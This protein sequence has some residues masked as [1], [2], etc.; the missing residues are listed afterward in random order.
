MKFNKN[1][2]IILTQLFVAAAAGAMAA[3]LHRNTLIESWKPVTVCAAIT[4]VI[5]GLL[6][7]LQ[8]Q[9][10]NN[11]NARI[12]TAITALLIFSCMT[13]GFYA[14]NYFGADDTGL[15]HTQAPV[16]SKYSQKRHH[17][18]RVGRN[19]YIPGQEYYVYYIALSLPN[20]KEKHQQVSAGQYINIRKGQKM[21]VDIQSGL[22]GVPVLKN[23]RIPSTPSTKK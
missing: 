9:N 2:A 13:C 3:A 14:I 6:V 17:S 20:G 15:I 11:T 7:S 19:R 10:F 16:I 18:R 5:E 1:I 12:R 8:L 23:L 21:S 22:F 4:I